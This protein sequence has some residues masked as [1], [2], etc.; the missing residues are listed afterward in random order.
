MLF[1]TLAAMSAWL[2]VQRRAASWRR[3]AERGFFASFF[4][5]LLVAVGIAQW[6]C[7]AWLLAVAGYPVPWAVHAAAPVAVYW[8]NRRIIGSM[9]RQRDGGAWRLVALRAYSAIAFTAL[10]CAVFL[11]LSNVAWG[12]LRVVVG[13]L[14]VEAGTI[15]R[16]APASALDGLFHWLQVGGVSSLVIAFVYGYTLGQRRLS[17]TR[18][19]VPLRYP[20]R[21]DGLRIVQISD[22]HIGQNLS[23]GQ[24]RRFVEGVNALA[25]DLVCITGDLADGPAADLAGQLPVLARLRARYGV[26]VILGNH[27]HYAGADAVVAAL[28]RFTPF[29]VLR[30]AIAQVTV[31]DVRLQII[32]LDD[33]GRDWARGVHH[34]PALERLAAHLA[35]DAPT[36][37]LSHRPEAF[38]H[39]ASLGIDLT[40]A[41]HTHGGQVAIPWFGRP[42]GLAAFITP[43]ERGLYERDGCF[44]YVNRGLGV[45]GQRIRLFTPREISLLEVAARDS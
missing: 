39:A 23:P 1:V 3:A 32:G 41:G 15:Q 9:R 20:S 36:L 19:R 24:L 29:T 13:V 5:L 11:G 40:L 45:T 35:A 17:V 34:H 38:T 8:F 26:F 27:D 2:A 7:V 6:S 12:V 10:F 43:F 44:L 18:L 21:L 37:L 42:R 14:T 28:R 22:I 4:T 25:P 31:N 16:A 30:D 33:V